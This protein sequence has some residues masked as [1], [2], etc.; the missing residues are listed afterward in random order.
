MKFPNARLIE[1]L[2]AR[3]DISRAEATLMITERF[4]VDSTIQPEDYFVVGRRT[5]QGGGAVPAGGAGFR[6]QI[7]LGNETP[8]GEAGGLVLMTGAYL[9]T[10]VATS[11]SMRYAVA[12]SITGALNIIAFSRDGQLSQGGAVPAQPR[13]AFPRGSNTAAVAGTLGPTVGVQL[14]NTP[15]EIKWWH[16]LT[17]GQAIYFDG[18]TDNQQMSASFWGE[19]WDLRV[20]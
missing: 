20:R 13:Y 6:S 15:L 4:V 8:L 5:F 10:P 17:A 9:W 16:L 12:N 19:E 3:M 2:A 1:L 18:G 14:G 7:G 11:I